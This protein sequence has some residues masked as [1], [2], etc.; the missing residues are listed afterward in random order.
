MRNWYVK[1]ASRDVTFNKTAFDAPEVKSK[2]NTNMT[3]E[4]LKQCDIFSLGVVLLF[5]CGNGKIDAPGSPE[6]NPNYYDTALERMVE[7]VAED[8]EGF[9]RSSVSKNYS[10]YSYYS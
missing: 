2:P 7:Q 6:S 4:G 1:L 8:D 5:I 9:R 3:F 10:Y